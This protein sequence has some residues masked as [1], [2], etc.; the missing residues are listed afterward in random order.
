M[1]WHRWFQTDGGLLARVGIGTCVFA[2]LAIHDLYRNG[3]N[4]RRWREYAYLVFAG[5]MGIAYGAANDLITASV[6][7]E[8]FYYGQGLFD[9]LGPKVPPDPARCIGRPPKSG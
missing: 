7:W 5:L 9:L 4:A 2:A 1:S 6:S 3:R 8:Y